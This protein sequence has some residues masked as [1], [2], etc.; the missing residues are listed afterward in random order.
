MEQRERESLKERKKESETD[1][2]TDRSINKQ[3]G[4]SNCMI[5]PG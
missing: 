5:S 4:D 1:R 3:D 2:R